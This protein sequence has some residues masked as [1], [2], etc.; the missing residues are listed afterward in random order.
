[1]I[2]ERTLRKA[3]EPLLQNLDAHVELM[4]EAG[5]VLVS[6]RETAIEKRNIRDLQWNDGCRT[7]YDGATY[8]RIGVDKGGSYILYVEGAGQTADDYS[9]LIASMT[10]V[11]LKG[12]HRI[13][14]EEL[15]R[16]LLLE[17]IN[18]IEI[19]LYA[20]DLRVE[21]LCNRCVIAFIT[22]ERNGGSIYEILHKAFPR[23]HGDIVLALDRRLI[24]LVKQMDEDDD[25]EQMLQLAQATYDTIQQETAIRVVVGIGGQVDTLL[26][27]RNSYNEAMEAINAGTRQ[28]PDTHIHAY[29]QM[30]LERFI[31]HV[32]RETGRK[33]F[34]SVLKEPFSKLFNDEMMSTIESFFENSLN[35]SETARRLYIHRNTLV[36][37]LD[38]VQRIT[39]LDLR[40]FDDAVTFKILLMI[41]RNIEQEG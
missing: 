19:Q 16:Q 6:S 13:D 34:R 2:S 41:G 31:Y 10:S 22:P 33:F 9:K 17:K 37:R 38:K 21:L 20:R 39:G 23:N 11:V 15:I 7:V 14:R 30:Q 18:E 27:V 25:M 8:S 5:N 12:A 32:P 35:I 36:Y 26:G 1:M 28:H 4:D 29:F 3:M 24:V 40:K